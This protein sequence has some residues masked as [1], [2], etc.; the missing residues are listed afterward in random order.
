V[1]NAIKMP[2]DLDINLKTPAPVPTRASE[3][4]LL[5]TVELE[6]AISDCKAKVEKI[7]KDCRSQNIKFR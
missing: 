3:P 5:V 6:N 1:P 2:R 7:A 4:S